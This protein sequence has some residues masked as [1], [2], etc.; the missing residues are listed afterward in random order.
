[1]SDDASTA[2][3]LLAVIDFGIQ[4][5]VFMNS[6]MGRYMQAR[7]NAEIE[8]ARESLETA[9]AEDPKAIRRLQQDA[10]SA[11]RF[12]QWMG[13]VVTEGEQAEYQFSQLDQDQRAIGSL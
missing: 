13:E 10:S 7:A 6:P 8:A 11:R 4:A 12:L 9:D 2:R 1:M 5:K 3:E